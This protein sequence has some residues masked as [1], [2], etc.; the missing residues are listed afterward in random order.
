MLTIVNT[1]GPEHPAARHSLDLVLSLVSVDR[2]CRVLF[3]GDSVWQ[4]MP[5]ART[6]DLLKKQALLPDLF[7][8]TSFYVSQESLTRLGLTP[9][10]FRVPVQVV[11]EHE[12][13]E[14]IDQSSQQLVF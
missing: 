7:D 9:A 4:L 1:V 10:Q 11:P 5:A 6:P 2:D 14:M 12:V 8:F 13:R 3:T